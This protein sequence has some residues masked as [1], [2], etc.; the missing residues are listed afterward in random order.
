MVNEAAAS[1]D[2]EGRIKEFQA[3]E[4]LLVTEAPAV[5]IYHRLVSDLI[6][7][8]V[9]GAALTPNKAGFGGLQWPG[10]TVYSDALS[11]MY[12]TKDVLNVR[13]SPPK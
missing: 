4:K 6:K 1:T 3:A 8:Y 10:Y 7:P 9:K 12:I 13:T 2:V 5:F 11:T